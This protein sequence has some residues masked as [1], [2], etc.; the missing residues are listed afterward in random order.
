MKKNNILVKSLAFLL[1]GVIIA[2]I[3]TLAPDSYSSF[4]N[5][6][7][8]PEGNVKAASTEDIL[9]VFEIDYN[10]KQPIIR[11]KK[12]EGLDYSPIIFFSVS[13]DIEEYILHI[14]PIQLVGDTVY[15]IPIVPNVNLPQSLNLSLPWNIINDTSGK[16]RI[17]HLNAFLDEELEFKMANS[18]LYQFYWSNNVNKNELSSVYDDEEEKNAIT[19][20]LMEVIFYLGDYIKW[21]E[22]GWESYVGENCNSN[23]YFI[24][25]GNVEMNSYQTRIVN[26]VAPNLL[27]YTDKI[28]SEME[29]MVYELNRIL[30]ENKGLKEE[31]ERLNDSNALLTKENSDL[32]DIILRLQSIIQELEM[33]P[34]APAL[35]PSPAP[36]PTPTPGP[37]PEPAPEPIPEPTPEP[38]PTPGPTPEPAPSPTPEPAPEPTPEPPPPDSINEPELEPI[39]PVEDG[40]IK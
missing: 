3:F 14:E 35:E 25:L 6:F 13:G 19:D 29:T 32:E 20:Y 9:E 8:S 38:E 37:T 12:A 31:I 26:Q 30:E 40:N 10:G 34:A 21:E 17:K 7:K 28:Y 5:L 24:P 27:E 22:V 16:I 36:E 2:L 33:T 11:L 4:R 23:Q 15:E 18:Y 1:V 39:Q